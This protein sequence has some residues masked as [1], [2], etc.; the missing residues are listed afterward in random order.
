MNKP[1]KNRTPA[2]IKPLCVEELATIGCESASKERPKEMTSFIG[3]SGLVLRDAKERGQTRVGFQNLKAPTG[4][5]A[6][7]MT[8][9]SAYQIGLPILRRRVLPSA[10][11]RRKVGQSSLAP[12]HRPW[13]ARLYTPPAISFTV[14]ERRNA[15]GRR[16]E[17][18]GPLDALIFGVDDRRPYFPGAYPW[19]CIGRL[20][21]SDG[22]SAGSAALVGR[23]L[24][25]TA[26]HCVDSLSMVKFVPAYYNGQSA[27]SPSLFSWASS[28]TY[29][30]NNEAAWDFALLRL[31]QPLGD[32]LG[33]FGVRTY[34]DSWDDLAV[35]AA[36]GYPS[37]SP[38]NN[39]VPSYLLGV[40][41]DDAISDGDAAELE[42][43]NQD[44]SKGN[45]GGPV[46]AV[47]PDGPYIVGVTS[48]NEHIDLLF[49]G[50][51]YQVLN[52]SGKAMVDMIALDRLEI[53]TSI[54]INPPDIIL[55]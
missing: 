17:L 54:R 25:L 3:L 50:D 40:A 28:I 24:V 53:D 9:S 6:W 22:S 8:V 55:R 14:H 31:Y 21:K 46:W 35:W 2:A 15:K 43:E 16:E 7:A 11:S 18:T 20:E 5:A 47:W 39:S 13:N 33:Y 44:N 30:N 10:R 32:Y 42:S 41:I 26:K 12:E 1:K 19:H 37:M 49:L 45:S 38:F 36:A 4:V 52:A 51:D 29:Y 23:D 27:V 48:R 34:H